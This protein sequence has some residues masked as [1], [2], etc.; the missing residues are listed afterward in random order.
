[1]PTIVVHQMGFL[2]MVGGDALLAKPS[3]IALLINYAAAFR[4]FT[5]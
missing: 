3:Y 1:M 2:V 5:W 4:T